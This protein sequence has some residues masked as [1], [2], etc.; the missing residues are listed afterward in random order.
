[1]RRPWRTFGIPVGAPLTG[2]LAD[3]LGVRPAVWSVARHQRH[4]R[5]AGGGPVLRDFPGPTTA[6]YVLID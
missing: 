5:G 4:V 1:M 6:L 3:A 2:V